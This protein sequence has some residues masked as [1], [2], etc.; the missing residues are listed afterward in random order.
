MCGCGGDIY[1]KHTTAP[2]VWVAA[3]A[4]VNAQGQ[5][6]VAQRA[7]GDAL[8]GQWEFPGGKIEAGETPEG[9]LVRE[10]HE[11]LGITL[12]TGCLHPLSFVSHAYP[13]RHV[14]MMLYIIRNWQGDISP[15]SH[16]ALAWHKPADLRTIDLLPADVP[17]IMPLYEALR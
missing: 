5:V 11:E 3:A 10:L 7:P 9:A 15:R 13:T 4:L 12:S 6:L 2:I 8:A 14:V 17:L 1:P 16:S